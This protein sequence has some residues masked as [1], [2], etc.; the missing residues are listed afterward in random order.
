MAVNLANSLVGEVEASYLC[1]TREEGMLEEELNEEVGYLFLNKKH[2]LD[3]QTFWKL[4]AFVKREQIDLVQAHGTSWFWGVLLKM[5]G[6]KIKLIWHDHYGE[7]EQLEQRDV[8]LLKPLARYFDGI[9]SVNETLKTWAEGQ[10]KNNMVIQ[11]NNFIVPNQRK[12][13]RVNL[14]GKETDFKII[15][16]ANLRP[17]KDHGNLL[18]AFSI[19]AARYNNV[20]LH[21]F[22]KDPASNY[23]RDILDRIANSKFK[24]RIYYY[25]A[26]NSVA[27]Y[28]R[29]ADLGVLSSKSEGLPLVLLEYAQAGIPI[30]STKVGACEEL[31]Q[32]S[33]VLVPPGCPE[34]LA[35]A[36]IKI[37][38][39][40]DEHLRNSEYIESIRTKFG[41]EKTITKL[42]RFYKKVYF[43][44]A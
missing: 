27:E 2:S 13:K 44:N 34:E 26:Q 17:Q 20:S 9:I 25:G 36:I 18:D 4:R 8:R 24:D 21:L 19:I 42:I 7:S 5:S 15:C 16:V 3:L 40:P 1:C 43:S 11:L 38:K 23:S 41:A 28:V 30:V 29:Q 12:G 22:G 37:Y 6:L 14:K 33:E 31:L 32:D 39:N 10:L 35:Q